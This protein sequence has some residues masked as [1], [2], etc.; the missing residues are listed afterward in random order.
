M[1]ETG[2]LERKLLTESISRWH[3][4]QS[5]SMPSAGGRL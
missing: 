1:D 5:D 2:H 3:K 4:E